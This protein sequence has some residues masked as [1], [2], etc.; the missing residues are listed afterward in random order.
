ME[1]MQ[2]KKARKS[3]KETEKA[4]K[5]YC[6]SITL[7]E[8]ADIPQ[9]KTVYLSEQAPAAN[10][11]RTVKK[12]RS[13][14]RIGTGK[15]IAFAACLALALAVTAVAG[16]FAG[17]NRSSDGVVRLPE[18]FK[19]PSNEIGITPDR[20]PENKY[21]FFFPTSYGY[22]VIVNEPQSGL[23][24]DGKGFVSLFFD[25]CGIDGIKVVKYEKNTVKGELTDNGDGTVT[26]TADITAVTIYLDGKDEDIP[27]DL[28]FKCLVNSV[29]NYDS[30]RKVI[31]YF[32]NDPVKIDGKSEPEGFGGFE[33][34][35]KEP[36][37]IPAENPEMTVPLTVRIVD[38]NGMPVSGISVCLEYLSGEAGSYMPG[39]ASTGSDG[40]VTRKAHPA[41][42][43]RVYARL[44]S[45]M[46]YTSSIKSRVIFEQTKTVTL[47]GAAEVSFVWDES[48]M[49]RLSDP[50]KSLKIKVVDKKGNVLPNIFVSMFTENGGQFILGYTDKN[51][52]A[53]WYDNIDGDYYVTL[54][55]ISYRD[56]MEVPGSSVAYKITLPHNGDTLTLVYDK[57]SAEISKD[58]MPTFLE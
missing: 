36:E 57:N 6:D 56:G 48:E 52:I 41:A 2:D 46:S 17:I 33:L 19:I 42:T 37:R 28:T 32:G 11:R 18:D 45:C 24:V 50:E 47:D 55:P 9:G 14:R 29:L 51:G 44:L 3:I 13:V 39:Y 43:Y 16:I 20:A 21:N 22:C 38:K 23:R 5:E 12:S 35:I 30:A 54:Y 7:P 53:T 8:M 27:D 10:N 58:T 31:L 49:I 34:K 25:K 26:K 4:I 1:K 15:Y 40:T